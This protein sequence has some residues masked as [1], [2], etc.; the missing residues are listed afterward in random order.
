[1]RRRLEALLEES[2]EAAKERERSAFD[3]LT[4]G[5][6]TKIVLFGAGGVGRQTLA[7]LRRAGVEPLA[8]ADNSP[9]SWGT[10][11]DGLDVLC[12]TDAVE[13]YS[14]SAVFVITI[15]RGERTD[16][17]RDHL[18][19]V[20]SLGCKHVASFGPLYWKYAESLLPHYAIDLPHKVLEQAGDVLAAF[21]LLGDDPSR[22]EFVSQ[23]AWRLT[24]DPDALSDPP[25]H[26]MYFPTHNIPLRSDEFFVD[27][28][29]FDGDTVQ[30]FL[31]QSHRHFDRI[32]AFEP[33][34]ANLQAL[35]ESLSALPPAIRDRIRVE[36][37]ALGERRK[38]VHFSAEGSLKSSVTESG[39]L[40][41]ECVALDDALAGSVPTYIKI[42][43]EGYELLALE[44]A[45]RILR[46]DAPVLAVCSYHKQSHL[47]EIPLLIHKLNPSYVL[48]QIRYAVDAWE[49]VTYAIPQNR[50]GAA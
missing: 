28:G 14:D 6:A 11:V 30:L 26:E 21:D 39:T 2:V 50:P 43:I 12:P 46:R 8:F 29:A 38:S 36:P 15:W 45:A 34:L 18:R 20:R 33:D 19:Q 40:T 1:M 44:G 5:L 13:R 4:G 7:A 31:D 41:V 32:V 22:E 10:V 17:M 47:W 48:R 24:M 42:D 27:C 37:Y 25:P 35:G 9:A 49:T 3:R 16:G 23:I